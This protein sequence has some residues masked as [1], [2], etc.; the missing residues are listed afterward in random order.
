M[1][2]DADKDCTS[3]QLDELLGHHW[4]E[5]RFVQITRDIVLQLSSPMNICKRATELTKLTL[6]DKTQS[7]KVLQH[8]YF[9]GQNGVDGCTEH[10]SI[11]L[12]MLVV[13]L[14]TFM[15]G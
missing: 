6:D 3:A 9:R 8:P 13:L 7:S 12:K 11:K 1:Q 10:A 5:I 2:S 4:R 14:P 15:V